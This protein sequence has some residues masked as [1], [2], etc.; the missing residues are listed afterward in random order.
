MPIVSRR[1]VLAGGAAVL[2]AAP[3]RGQPVPVRAEYP[4]LAAPPASHAVTWLDVATEGGTYR[5]FRA[6]PR[7]AAPADGW[8]SLWMLDG[9]A[10]F[11]RLTADELGAVPGLVIFGVGYPVATEFDFDARARDYT[12]EGAGARADP[13]QPERETGGD[14]RF[15]ARLLGPLRAAAEA[16]VAVDPGGRCLWGHSYGGLFTLVTLL[17]AP[18][19]FRRY[20]AVS[21]SLWFAP[22]VLAGIEAAAPAAA[23]GTGLMLLHGGDEGRGQGPEAKALAERLARRGDIEVTSEALPGLG[24]GATLAGSFGRALGYATG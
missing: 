15:R 10:V 21:P 5:L 2:A 19:A 8:R 12:P 6:V 11:N 22:E 24:H 13:R 1:S 7:A 17:E 9:N 23:A 18:G 16:G 20:V 14:R 3:V 4:L